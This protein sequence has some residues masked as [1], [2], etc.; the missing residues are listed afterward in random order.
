MSND[1]LSLVLIV[2]FAF[3]ASRAL[4]A[5][6][7]RYVSLSG[8]EYL[9][10]G[11]LIGPTTRFQVLTEDVLVHLEPLVNLLLGLFGFLVGIDAKSAFRSSGEAIV[12]FGSSILV[13]LGTALLCLPILIWVGPSLAESSSFTLVREL[14]QLGPFTIELYIPSHHLFAASILGAAATASSSLVI[15]TA[16]RLYRSTGP[17]GALL[18]S[19]ARASQVTGILLL[20][21]VLALAR[22]NETSSL[23][24]QMNLTEWELAA[25]AVGIV[26]GLLFGLFLGKE[27]DRSRIFL[28]SVGLVTFAAGVGTAIGISPIFVNMIAGLTVILTSPHGTVLRQHLTQLTHPL[29]VLLMIF[30]GALWVPVDAPL[31]ILVPV[32]ALS[33]LLARRITMNALAGSFLDPPPSTRLLGSGLWAPGPLAVALAVS[34]ALRFPTLAP[35][36]MSVTIV[37]TLLSELYSQRALRRLLDDVGEI[38]SKHEPPKVDDTKL[39]EVLG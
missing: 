38:P 32:F 39:E 21:L 8:A 22:A 29:F 20:G 37:G 19:T 24:Y 28:A 30:A 6:L 34:G 13:A 33:R 5:R 7:G 31:W 16:R 11:V 35:L 17:V 9:L 4:T 25:I 18:E 10:V 26:C 12:G 1:T 27:N 3:A 2:T 15:I 36:L 23:H 14:A